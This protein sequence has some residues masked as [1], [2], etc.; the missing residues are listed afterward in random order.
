M[1]PKSRQLIASLP[2][3][4]IDRWPP[5]IAYHNSLLGSGFALDTNARVGCASVY[6]RGWWLLWS[7]LQG[8]SDLWFLANPLPS[9]EL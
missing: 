2:L 4:L 9:N 7:K 6:T 1:E 3:E 5:S 8:G